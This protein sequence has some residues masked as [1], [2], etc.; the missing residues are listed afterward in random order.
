MAGRPGL[1]RTSCHGIERSYAD[2]RDRDDQQEKRPVEQQ[3]LLAELELGPLEGFGEQHAH[4]V[5]PAS[6]TAG[7]TSI[8]WLATN[9]GFT[10]GSRIKSSVITSWT[11]GAAA[12]AP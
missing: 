4:G 7:A 12:C 11:I 3:Q 1:E 9:T 10:D 5:P 8:S 2:D 6:A